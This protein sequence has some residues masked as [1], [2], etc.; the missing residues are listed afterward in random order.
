MLQITNVYIA[1]L[2]I[3][4]NCYRFVTLYYNYQLISLIIG[5]IVIIF[6]LKGKEK[7]ALI[8]PGGRQPRAERGRGLCERSEF[9]SPRA[10]RRRPSEKAR[11][12]AA[13]LL[14]SFFSPK[15][16]MNKKPLG[17]PVKRGMT[18]P[19][20]S[21]RCPAHASWRLLTPVFGVHDCDAPLVTLRPKTSRAAPHRSS[22]VNL[23]CHKVISE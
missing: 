2:H 19:L 18:I 4:F 9:R 11:Y 14:G 15:R 20:N 1:Y 6:I 10:R 8:G 16:R 7:T 3:N 22:P 12:R 5:Y 17:F 23:L 13:V 21:V